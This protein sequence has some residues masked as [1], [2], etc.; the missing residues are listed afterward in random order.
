[1]TIRILAESSPGEVRVAA[2]D[3]GALLDYAIWRPGAP[4]GVSGICIAAG[5]PRAFPRWPARS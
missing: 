5:S 2:V 3:G 4:D 1:V